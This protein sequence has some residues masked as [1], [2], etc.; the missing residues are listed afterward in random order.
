MKTLIL[1]GSPRPA[2]DTAAL[3][4]RLE[5]EL[6]GDV[7]RVDCYRADISPCVD[8]RSCMKTVGCA[9]EDGMQEVYSYL[10][11]CH[12]VVIASPL[13]FS[14]L[15]GRLL[16][17]CSRFQ[18]LYCAKAFVGAEL[19]LLPKKGGIIITGG[20]DGRPERAVQTASALLHTAGARDIFPPVMSLNTNTL[21]AGED[22]TA[23]CG[24]TRLADFLSAKLT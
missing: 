1:N 4:H 24:I 8:C 12:N 23:L 15:T 2:G 7:L 5:K 20:G 6:E 10:R 11:D 13:Y 9:V 21:P 18:M 3:L 19:S 22:M 14:E 17:V 16:D